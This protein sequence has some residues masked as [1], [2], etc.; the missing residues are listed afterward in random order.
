MYDIG[1]V[2]N[3]LGHFFPTLIPST[4]VGCGTQFDIE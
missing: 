4:C 1:K 2:S 3:G